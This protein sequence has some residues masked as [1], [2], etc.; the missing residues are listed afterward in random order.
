MTKNSGDDKM[1]EKINHG[2]WLRCQPG[3][4]T[5]Q[6][7]PKAGG[8]QTMDEVQAAMGDVLNSC[9]W[10]QHGWASTSGGPAMRD[11]LTAE[12]PQEPRGGAG[13]SR[14]LVVHP[15]NAGNDHFGDNPLFGRP[16]CLMYHRAVRSY[17]AAGQP[18]RF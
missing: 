16:P 14:C 7:V 11:E 18:W 17:R 6:K 3:S 2:H 8:T 1:T 12:P 9:S 4:A 13:R 15:I 5:E 10:H